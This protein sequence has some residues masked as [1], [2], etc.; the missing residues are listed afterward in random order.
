MSLQDLLSNAL[1][2][3]IL[4]TLIA[5]AITGTGREFIR[6]NENRGASPQPVDIEEWTKP[7]ERDDV[8][9]DTLRV[10]VALRLTQAVEASLLGI[11]GEGVPDRPTSSWFRGGRNHDYALLLPMTEGAGWLLRLERSAEIE[12]LRLTVHSGPNLVREARRARDFPTCP[13]GIALLAICVG[14]GMIVRTELPAGCALPRPCE[15][16][17]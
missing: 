7:P 15:A 2:A 9:P 6:S 10:E 12:D 17:R 11:E 8:P 5:A 14:E 13:G 3:I 16:L 4:L 1:A